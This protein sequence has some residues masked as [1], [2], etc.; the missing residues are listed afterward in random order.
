MVDGQSFARASERS[1]TARGILTQGN[2]AS[3]RQ[4]ACIVR[5]MNIPVIGT[6]GNR[7]ESIVC[8]AR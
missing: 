4:L 2:S 1:M 5:A 6:P 8:I 3:R 7:L